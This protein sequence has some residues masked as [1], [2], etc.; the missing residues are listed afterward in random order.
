[1]ASEATTMMKPCFDI[2]KLSYQIFSILESKFLFGFDDP[3][4]FAT[5]NPLEAPVKPADRFPKSS[6]AGKVRILSID[7]GNAVIAAVA[8]ARLEASLAEQ[9]G[10]STARIADFFDLAAGSGAGGVLAAMLFTCAP[11]GRPLFS[12]DEALRVVS[13][14]QRK[15]PSAMR[16]TIFCRSGG[17][18]H[19]IFG[20]STLRNTIK[21]VLI[22]CYDLATGAPF[23]F[24]RADAVEA[25]AFDFSIRDVCAATCTENKTVE[26]RSVDGRSRIRAIGGSIAMRNPTATAITHVLNNKL[27]F[28]LANNVEDLLVVSLG[29]SNS[30]P[31]ELVN[32]A[33]E[34]AAEMVDQ[35]V[36]MAF[37]QNGPMATSYVR[38]QANFL[39]SRGM[40]PAAAEKEMLSQRSVDSMLFRGRKVSDRTNG[41]RLECFC[42]ELIAEHNRRKGCSVS[43]VMIKPTVTPRM[44]S[45]TSSTTFTS[46]APAPAP[47]VA[48]L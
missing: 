12:A 10:D 31:T 43:T 7:A 22:P 36:A 27:E 5:G 29:S 15:F 30:S 39:G 38:I 18:Y 40:S 42:R 41:E 35:A 48:S 23:V 46:T 13:K 20:E 1:M 32:I 47:A 8:L 9:C 6:S 37:R 17:I 26:I 3:R 24:S 44:S 25:D 11:D 4:L 28:P 16:K 33:G 19:R 34:N 45:A 2:N 21:P 14:N